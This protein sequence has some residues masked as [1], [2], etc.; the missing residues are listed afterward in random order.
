MEHV[1]PIGIV[2]GSSTGNTKD[3]A[4]KLHEMLGGNLHDIS[5][6]DAE[7]IGRYDKL[8]FATSTWGAGDLQDDWEVF[9]PN[10]DEMDFAGKRV[11]ILGLGD[12][13]HYPD[14]FADAMAILA[15]KVERQG[16]LIVGLTPAEGYTYEK[17]RAVRN[18]RFLGLAVDEDSQSGCTDE[19]LHGW[20]ERLRREF[21]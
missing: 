19:R 9:L 2:Y 12:Q 4:V 20:A 14:A 17:S 16:G 10:L 11:A 18:G 21:A 5:E 1:M 3:V 15:D 6:V 13:E 7:T 8:V